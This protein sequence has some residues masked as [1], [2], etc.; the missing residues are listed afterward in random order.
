MSNVQEIK[1]KP[2]MLHLDKDRE[3]RY[4]LNSLAEMEEKYGSV[5]KALEAVSSES[6]KAIRFMI[7]VGQ[8]DNED[9]LTELQVGSYIDISSLG[10]ISEAL[11]KAMTADLPDNSKEGS[12]VNPNK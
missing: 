2:I 3:L 11:N 4:T 12:S 1:R 10:E 7:W 9:A 6:I 8:I 5:D